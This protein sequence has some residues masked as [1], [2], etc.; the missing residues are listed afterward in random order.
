MSVGLSRST[1]VSRGESRAGRNF[2][3]FSPMTPAVHG[4]LLAPS[5]PMT[6]SRHVELRQML[7]RRHRDL[8]TQVQTKVRGFREIDTSDTSRAELSEDKVQEDIDFALVQMQS[9]TM[10]KIA[11][12]L[13]RLEAG[14]YG[15]CRDC[16]QEIA[17]KRL[18][19]LP[20]ATRCKDCQDSAESSA[21]RA[22]RTMDRDASFRIGTMSETSLTQ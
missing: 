13:G 6:H 14:E 18:L 15:M 4:P 5:G 10:E 8:A 12:A 9:Q 7:E 17:E 20:F 19:A 16:Q 11:A 1:K 21:H 3:A 2:S 22:R